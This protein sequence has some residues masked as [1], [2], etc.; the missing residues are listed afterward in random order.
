MVGSKTPAD[1][2][3][4]VTD[5]TISPPSGLHIADIRDRRPDVCFPVNLGTCCVDPDAILEIQLVS[6]V[7]EWIYS[8][9]SL[10]VPNEAFGHKIMAWTAGLV[11]DYDRS[12]KAIDRALEL[13][14]NDA[15]ALKTRGALM[16]FT[17][18]PAAAIGEFEQARRLDPADWGLS[19]HFLGLAHLLLGRHET[20]AVYFKERILLTPGTDLARAML[21]STLGH[22][23]ETDEAQ[24]V[25]AELKEINP[26]YSFEV[27]RSRMPFVNPADA[28]TIA[29]GLSKAGLG[30]ISTP[31]TNPAGALPNW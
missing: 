28:D 13:A 2:G 16:F 11:G 6:G 17:G 18:D 23:G 15:D 4:A 22:L 9:S 20:A 21:A 8:R 10:L 1:S 3:N 12:R 7:L 24:R 31:A 19:L 29:E 5:E 27:H 26:D 14:P 30:R 25:R